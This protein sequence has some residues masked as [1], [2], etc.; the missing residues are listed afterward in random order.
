M[1]LN[2]GPEQGTP[3]S[4][5][6]AKLITNKPFVRRQTTSFSQNTIYPPI[7]PRAQGNTPFGMVERNL[8]TWMIWRLI[9]LNSELAVYNICYIIGYNMCNLAY[10]FINDVIR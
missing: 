2:R 7:T 8:H 4:P 3:L 6:V 10:N 1:Q 5:T 9:I